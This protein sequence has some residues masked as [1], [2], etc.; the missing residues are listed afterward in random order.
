MLLLLFNID[1]NTKSSNVLCSCI[2][3]DLKSTLL[4]YYWT[5]LTFCC[6]TYTN[7]TI[8]INKHHTQ[9]VVRNLDVRHKYP[10]YISSAM[11]VTPWSFLLAGAAT[12]SVVRP[13][14]PL[15]GKQTD[16][17]D[18]Q[19]IIRLPWLKESHSWDTAQK[20]NVQSS[21]SEAHIPLRI[22]AIFNNFL[23]DTNDPNISVSGRR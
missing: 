3:Y 5:R 11:H 14:D 23:S 22:A 16:G 21:I 9:I 10:S 13:L 19:A 2:F 6:E 17:E 15:Q 7:S 18:Y 4:Y 1:T 20:E 12:L 8:Y